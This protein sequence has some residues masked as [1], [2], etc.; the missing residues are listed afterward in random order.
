MMGKVLLALVAVL[1]AGVVPALAGSGEARVSGRLVEI[2]PD[3]RLV[4]EEQG[5]WAG[6][7]T[8]IL[9]R[10]VHL[11][12]DTDIRVVRPTRTWSSSDAVPGY[13]IAPG[14]FRELRMGDFITVTTGENAR[15]VAIDVV[16]P[17]GADAGLASP[18][19]ESGTR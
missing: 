18:P 9:T 8:G 11:G 3:G 10:T 17:D 7:R 4:I 1:L 5:P 19:T 6:P 2:R 15:A 13:D 12:P 14:D 16:R